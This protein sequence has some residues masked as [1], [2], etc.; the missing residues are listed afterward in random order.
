MVARLRARLAQEEG[1]TLIELLTTMAIMGFVLSAII[2]VFVSGL[3]AE[4]D[5]NQRF[6]AQQ[7]ARLALQSMRKDLRTA[8]T[9][10]VSTKF[11]TGDT[12]LLGYCSNSTTTWSSTPVSYTTWCARSEGGT[13]VHY[14]LFRENANDP[15]V[16]ATP[17]GAGVRAADWLTT[18]SVFTCA[19][20]PVGARPE[21]TVSVPVD[22]APAKTGGVY[23]LADTIMLRNAAAGA[24]S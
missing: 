24:C 1:M 18:A 6:Q 10:S 15:N 17:A 20:T 22:A 21:L 19:V 4:V 11:V 9:E 16:C 2:G 8:C 13:P 7:E 12:V 14:G 5:M 3:H 23:T